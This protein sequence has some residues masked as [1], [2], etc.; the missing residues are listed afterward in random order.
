MREKKLRSET[1]GFARLVACAAVIAVAAV[2]LA[3]CGGSPA[4]S[5]PAKG[6]PAGAAPGQA[7]QRVTIMGTNAL[8]FAPMIVRVRAGRVRITLA[9]SGS[10]PHDLV[11][12]LLKVKSATVSG[13]P[14]AGSVSLTVTFPRPGRY[15]FHCQYHQSAGMTGVFVVS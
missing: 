11:I 4:R 1:S 15:P 7:G 10:Y 9:D 5:A 13:D 2:L 3:G 12:P 6:S 8:R 14:G